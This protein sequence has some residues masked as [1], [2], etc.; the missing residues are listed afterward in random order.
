MAFINVTSIGTIKY[1]EW[2][3]VSD[4]SGDYTETSNTNIDGL[5]IRALFIPN[6]GGTQPSDLYDVTLL[7]EKLVD[8]LQG[9]GANRSNSNINDVRFDTPYQSAVNEK[10]KLVVANAGN[11]KGGT[12]RIYYR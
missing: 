1:A 6:S 3:W 8:V 12:V 7:D 4:A 5:I 9:Y 2:T 11:A 10:L